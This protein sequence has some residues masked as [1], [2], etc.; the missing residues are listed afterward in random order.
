MNTKEP[1][2]S[3]EGQ[4][5]EDGEQMKITLMIIMVPSQKKVIS[6]LSKERKKSQSMKTSTEISIYHNLSL[7]CAAFVRCSY[8]LWSR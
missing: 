3:D 8:W 5:L 4:L 7:I 1:T 2:R 6:A